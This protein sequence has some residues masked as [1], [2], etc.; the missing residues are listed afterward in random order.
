[1][2]SGFKVKQNLRVVES[3]A[4]I[5]PAGGAMTLP[6]APPFLQGQFG[7]Q[8]PENWEGATCDLPQHSAL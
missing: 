8:L 3:Q 4:S 5:L 7:L 6:S 1:M 2:G